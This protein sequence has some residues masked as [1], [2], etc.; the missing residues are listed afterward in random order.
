MQI[1]SLRL[2]ISS[3][4]RKDRLCS[5]TMEDSSA[6]E[7][8]YVLLKPKPKEILKSKCCVREG[9]LIVSREGRLKEILIESR[10]FLLIKVLYDSPIIC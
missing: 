9:Q 4:H 10:F 5:A 1:A 2:L 6:M 3:I 8:I 7:R